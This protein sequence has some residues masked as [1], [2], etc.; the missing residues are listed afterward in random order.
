MQHAIREIRTV[1]QGE[2]KLNLPKIFWGQEVE[3]IILTVENKGQQKEQEKKNL[4]KNSL[5]GCL[6]KYA[7]P[8][9]IEIEHDAWTQA[10]KDKHVSC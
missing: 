2:I 7:K 3:I 9:L 5:K 8:E 4:R 6:Q 10:V 1:E